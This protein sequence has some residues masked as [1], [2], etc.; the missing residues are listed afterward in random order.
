MQE[1]FKIGT[2]LIDYFPADENGGN[3]DL[4]PGGY[5]LPRLTR[6]ADSSICCGSKNTTCCD[7]GH[8]VFLD[9]V[10]QIVRNHFQPQRQLSGIPHIL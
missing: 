8:G 9:A 7:D 4:T 6:C 5:L 3:G 1:A 10:G 2:R